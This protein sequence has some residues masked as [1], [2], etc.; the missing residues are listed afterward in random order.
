MVGT[1]KLLFALTSDCREGMIAFLYPD[2]LF[3]GSLII[4]VRCNGIQYAGGKS[5][6][7]IINVNPESM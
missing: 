6:S 7:V 2:D 3:E 5:I 4:S 1:S